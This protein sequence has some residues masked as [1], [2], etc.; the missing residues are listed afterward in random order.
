MLIGQANRDG[1]NKVESA[2]RIYNDL[3]R[4]YELH[5][6][7]GNI[8][9]IETPG[10]HSYHKTSWERIFSFFFEHLMGKNV[11]PEQAGDIDSSPESL[12]SEEELKVYVDGP[13]PDDRT[14]TIQDSF[15]QQAGTPE[16]STENELSNFR[17]SVKDFLK[18]R[19]FGAFPEN[20]PAFDTIK[21]FRTLDRAKYGSDIYNF[22]SEEGWRLKVDIRWRNDPS[23]KKPL[24]IVL[25]NRDEN[26]WESESAMACTPGFSMDRKN[27]GF[28]AGL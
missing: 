17:T 2:D 19:S 28:N 23:L 13:P 22:V 24:M 20:P 4:I 12:L 3:K 6:V 10:G 27:I 1:L 25:C 26:R 16:K 9:Y 21:V 15:V 8:G 11:T 14:T 7:P 18:T 5:G